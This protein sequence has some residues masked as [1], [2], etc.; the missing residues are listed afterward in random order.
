MSPVC[1]RRSHRVLDCERDHARVDAGRENRRTETTRDGGRRR[2]TTDTIGYFWY[3]YFRARNEAIM[4]RPFY[5]S[6]FV[7]VIFSENNTGVIC[8]K[9]FQGFNY[10]IIPMTD[11]M[12][13]PFCRIILLILP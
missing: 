12:D 3:A 4:Y 8:L 7:K 2:G 6:L 5:N 11:Y 9:L 1:V 13:A 10:I